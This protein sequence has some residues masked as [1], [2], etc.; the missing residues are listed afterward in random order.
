MTRGENDQNLPPA[1]SRKP[2]QSEIDAALARLSIDD[3]APNSAGS[4]SAGYAKGGS[5]TSKQY[6]TVGPSS[7][8]GKSFLNASNVANGAG[9]AATVGRSG[10]PGQGHGRIPSSSSTSALNGAGDP[11]A[12]SGAGRMPLL[13]LAM[14]NV[15]VQPLGHP[16]GQSQQGQGQGV[17]RKASFD[18]LSANA[19]TGDR[20]ARPPS[21]AASRSAAALTNGGAS[22]AHGAG[23]V[24]ASR[25]GPSA[26]HANLKAA[27]NGA[28]GAAAVDLGRYDGGLER[29]EMRGRGGEVKGE[30]AAC[31]AVDSADTK[32]QVA[33]LF[34]QS[35]HPKQ[36]LTIRPHLL[37]SRHAHPPTRQW[38]M[39]SFE[40]GRALGKG[41]FGRVYMARTRQ[42]P[43]Y[44]V[45][46]KCMYKKELIDSR[47]EKQLRRE[48]EIQM[49]L[50]YV[51]ASRCP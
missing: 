46:L 12:A 6:A 41:K 50:R 31:L 36:L 42:P 27:G 13:K 26:S 3:S 38:S 16:S 11:H 18:K 23:G 44:I 34:V 29:D 49:N 35:G 19:A 51:S 39:T 14:G 4:A 1:S 40:I 22:G 25:I 47:V 24:R 43:G 32:G 48:I 8:A 37:H 30:A 33:H 5:R 20:N 15:M 21:M 2:T 9:G 28:T 10:L 7:G 45:A 17:M